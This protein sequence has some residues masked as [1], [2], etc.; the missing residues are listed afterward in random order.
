MRNQAS[1]GEIGLLLHRKC[2]VVEMGVKGGVVTWFLMEG[3]IRD[4]GGGL[5]GW[6]GLFGG[7]SLIGGGADCGYAWLGGVV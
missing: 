1:W 3:W 5:V 7:F 6:L 4:L 2:G